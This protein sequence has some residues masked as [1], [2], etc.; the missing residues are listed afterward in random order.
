MSERPLVDLAVVGAGPAG[1]AAARVASSAGLSVV[2]IDAGVRPGGQ[3]WRHPAGSF[4]PARLHHD[5][6]RFMS[7]LTNLAVIRL[8]AHHVWRLEPTD[9]GWSIHCLIGAE[10]RQA[11]SSTTVRARRLV[12]ACGAYDRQLPFPGWDLPGVMTAGGVQSLLK[13]QQVVAGQRVVVAGTGPFLLPVA[14]GL[15]RYGARVAAVI[16][17][18][19]PLTFA[20]TPW[21]IPRGKVLEA[22]GYAGS[23]ARY[24]IPLH[25]RQVVV[26]A[27]GSG[28][29]SRV[30]VRGLD[31]R[32]AL[33]VRSRTISCDVLAV[34][35][36][37]TPQLE[38]ALQAGCA[39]HLDADSSLVV[40]VDDQLRTNVPSVWAAG[41]ITGVGGADLAWTEG[42]LA[43]HSVVSSLRPSRIFDPTALRRRRERLRRFAVALSR[44]YPV[45]P[46]M[47]A[48]VA[49][50]I[51]VCRCEEV[52]AGRIRDAVGSLG[53]TDA[54]AVKMLARPGM[55]WCQGRVCG[56]ATACITARSLDR[57][58]TSADL[59]AFAGRPLATPVPLGVLAAADPLASPS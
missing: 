48:S 12:L 50:P 11:A 37:F 14:V 29:L 1:L 30:V 47:V 5:W 38:L 45:P 53:A 15:A 57:P 55:G 16:E 49:D 22:L 33:S 52:P 3:F 58:V 44:V 25:H 54:R 17:A 4:A 19:S 8:A 39:T 41:E 59:Q 10:P 56:F 9:E 26:G 21:S 24:R 13:G 51:L 6:D 40:D 18:N 32:G 35:W 42:E 20:R 46:A 36:G 7:A 31:R 2:L 28:Q 34:G 23:L 27:E 43:G